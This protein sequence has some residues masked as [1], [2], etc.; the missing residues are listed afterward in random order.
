MYASLAEFKTWLELPADDEGLQD[1]HLERVLMAADRWIDQHCGRHFSLE[2]EATKLYYPNEEGYL[3]VVDLISITTLKMDT[4]GDRTYAT[5]LD[6]DDYEL[7]PY[8]DESG[9]PSVRFQKIRI[10]PLSSQ[11]FGLGELVQIVGDFGYVIDNQ[12]PEEVRVASL[13]LASRW[14]K[15]HETPL[16]VLSMT[17][18]GTFE[19]ISKSDP[20]VELLLAQYSRTGAQWVLV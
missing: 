20:D 9:R 11:A 18:L 5:T 8:M 10:W 2:N 13:L 19:R 7:L 15:R 17:D 14:W 12:P 3:D 6:P 1:H 16:G 4:D